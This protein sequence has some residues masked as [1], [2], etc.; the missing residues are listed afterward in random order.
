M[1]WPFSGMLRWNELHATFGFLTNACGVQGSTTNCQNSNIHSVKLSILAL[2]NEF[3]C[4]RLLTLMCTKLQMLWTHGQVALLDI[5]LSCMFDFVSWLT[6]GVISSIHF[7][8]RSS[9]LVDFF[10]CFRGQNQESLPTAK[11]HRQVADGLFLRPNKAGFPNRI[12][13]LAVAWKVVFCL[14]E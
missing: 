14:P 12:Q 5:V 9:N 13:F 7:W 4:V 2:S 11:K 6:N 8:R 1:T 10:R 3:E